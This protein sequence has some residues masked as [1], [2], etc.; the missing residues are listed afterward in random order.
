MVVGEVLAVARCATE[1]TV[2]KV[3]EQD[4]KDGSE[5]CSR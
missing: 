1:D 5:E 3:A 2:K 4:G